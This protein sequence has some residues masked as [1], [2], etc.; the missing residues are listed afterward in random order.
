M[1]SI[2]FAYFI[3]VL[4]IFSSTKR[5]SSTFQGS[6]YWQWDEIEP[7]D[8]SSYP[9]STE[10]LFQGMPSNTDAALTWTNGHVYA[11]KGSQFWRVD[12]QVE[13]ASPLSTAEHWMHCDD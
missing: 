6:A 9:K 1:H 13:K 11:F 12:Q 3:L 10:K 7:T 2:T 8:F 4:L 5:L